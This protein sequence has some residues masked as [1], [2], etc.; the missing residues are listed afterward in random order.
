MYYIKIHN[1]INIIS[2]FPFFNKTAL[3]STNQNLIG[4][5]QGHLLYTTFAASPPLPPGYYKGYLP[6]EQL[7]HEWPGWK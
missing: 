6:L 1:L 3:F 5:S 4:L 7:M 2:I